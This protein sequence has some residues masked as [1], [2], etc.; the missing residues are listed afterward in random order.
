MY[1]TFCYG[2]NVGY[3]FVKTGTGACNGNFLG[4]GADDCYTAVD[5]EQ[6]APF[7]LL[8]SNGEFTSFHGTE[9]DHGAG[10]ATIPAACVLSI[11]P[12]GG[13]A[14]R[15]LKSGVK[16]P[17]VSVIVLSCNG[18]DIRRAGSHTSNRWLC[19]G[20]WLRISGRTNRKSNSGEATSVAP[21][22]PTISL[23]DK[24]QDH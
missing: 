4:I 16:E 15:S 3:K 6:S 1:N 17:W 11:A 24:P 13:P 19:P 2:Y 10:R 14:I 20:A 7:G 23:P 5:V 8:I 21:S 22:F 12:F 18:I 9:P